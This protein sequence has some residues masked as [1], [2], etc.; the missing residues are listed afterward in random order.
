MRS[1]LS[2]IADGR[3]IQ[4][5]RGVVCQER[6]ASALRRTVGCV[7]SASAHERILD[8]GT[9]T[10][11]AASLR[12]EAYCHARCVRGDSIV[13]DKQSIRRR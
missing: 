7:V 6:L 8:A 12:P 9:G 5:A 3:R 1:D 13:N 2:E 11:F 4:H 10:G